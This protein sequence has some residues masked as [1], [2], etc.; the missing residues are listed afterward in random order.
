MPLHK[1]SG[2]GYKIGHGHVMHVSAGR[3]KAAYRAYLAKKHGAK[4]KK[5]P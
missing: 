2:G 5:Y 1:V 4:L 3:A